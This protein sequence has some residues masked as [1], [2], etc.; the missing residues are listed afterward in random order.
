M[1]GNKLCDVNG[2]NLP[3]CE[4]QQYYDQDYDYYDYDYDCD[5]FCP[6]TR[7]TMCGNCANLDI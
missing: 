3:S 2:S 5:T 7:H 4:S 1:Q 6:Q